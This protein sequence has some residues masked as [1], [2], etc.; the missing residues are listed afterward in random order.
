MGNDPRNGYGNDRYGQGGPSSGYNDRR[1][2][3]GNDDRD[4]RNGGPGYGA[5]PGSYGGGYS[6]VDR[7]GH[8]LAI[9]THM[10]KAPWIPG[11]TNDRSRVQK[12]PLLLL[13]T[14]VTNSRLLPIAS[15]KDCRCFVQT[16]LG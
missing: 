11:G 3:Y 6:G 13:P 1:D 12:S 10:E 15:D 2:G 8:L 14:R 5:P 7:V 4:Y 9:M 16:N